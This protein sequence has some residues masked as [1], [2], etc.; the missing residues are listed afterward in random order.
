MALIQSQIQKLNASNYANWQCDIK[1]LLMEKNVY[2]I[3]IEAEKCPAGSA[4]TEKDIKDFKIRSKL[5]LSLI[6]L[7]IEPDYRKIIE[8]C[9]CPVQAWKRLRTHFYPDTRSRHMRIF[10][11]LCECKIGESE[12]IDL[13][14]ARLLRIANQLKSV[15][16]KFDDIYVTFQLLRFLPPK[17]DSM[18]QTILRWSDSDFKFDDVVTALVAEETRLD[19]R[20]R[21][22]HKVYAEAQSIQHQKNRKKYA[23]FYCGRPGHFKNKCR[24]YIKSLARRDSPASA[25]LTSR[26]PSPVRRSTSPVVCQKSKSKY[27]HRHSAQKSEGARQGRSRDTRNR[28]PECKSCSSF[29]ISQ[30]NLI[31][32][33][34][35]W[36]FD[37]AASHHFCKDKSLFI[38]F[39]PLNDENMAVAVEGIT[40]P[41]EGRGTIKL[42]FGQRTLMF[43][44]VM[45]SPKLRRNLISGA[46]I[47]KNGAHFN[48]G[49]GEVKISCNGQFLFKAILKNGIYYIYP[50]VPSSNNK[51]VRFETSAVNRQND[52]MRWHRRLAHVSPYLI[53]HTCKNVGAR[54]LPFLRGENF[55]C[56]MCK[57]N[58]Y[59]RTSFKAVNFIRSKSPLELLYT[60]LWGPSPVKGR[61][62]ERYFISIIDDYSRKAS[63]YPIKEKSE[64]FEVLKQHIN[65][66]ERFL[67][68]KV[69]AIRSD[70]G[71]EFANEKFEKYCTERGINHEY[72]NTFSPEQNG[73]IERYN[74]TVADGARTM[75]KDSGLHSSFWP[76]AMLHFTYTWNRLCHKNQSKTPYELF[77]GFKPSVRHLRPFGCVA[78]VGVP[79]QRR[80]KFDSKARRGY[81]VGYAFRTKG[82]R[83]WLPEEDKIIETINVSFDESTMFKQHS[84]EA[85]MGTIQDEFQWV[86]TTSSDSEDEDAVEESGIVPDISS[87]PLESSADSEGIDQDSLKEPTIKQPVLR[88]TRWIRKVVPRTIGDKRDIYYF[89]I[90]NQSHRLRS[91]REVIEYC[92]KN[93][94]VF[95]PDLFNFKKRDSYEG[96][97]SSPSS[98]P[99]PSA[100]ICQSQA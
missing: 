44:D 60:D 39:T 7:N 58:K 63:L 45:Y 22:Q 55:N 91:P 37:T 10:T 64:A 40:F 9:D 79:R 14:A 41:I 61:K 28:S 74:Q 76:E 51:K 93:N 90:E 92:R 85:V 97:V 16:K 13:Y 66:V 25:N 73:T 78:Y 88:E 17:F 86:P 87:D 20:D 34:A 47:D 82:F 52:M 11:E 21:D 89:D 50:K 42:K 54:G 36:V 31:D 15:N 23:C 29:F 33:V 12:N 57:L 67:G 84:E 48:G 1:Y 94:L 18:V 83:I 75:L 26:D 38:D 65:R 5:A 3:V 32:G 6:Y 19:L 95:K 71:G 24:D 46:R 99:N 49:G 59:R 70:N 72:T 2:D 100:D 27:R 8:N 81:L 69:K 98:S 43:K 77:G 56:E 62:G 4:V 53:E 80:T 96:I 35:D 68:R 30:A